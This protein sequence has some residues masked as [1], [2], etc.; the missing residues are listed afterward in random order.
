MPVL[1]GFAVLQHLS[2]RRSAVF[3]PVVV[4]T[5][6]AT[7]DT[8]RRALALGATDFLTKPLDLVEVGL[9]VSNLLSLRRLHD[10]VLR[11][12]LTL[13]EMVADRTRDLVVAQQEIVDRLGLAA[14][15][16]D[17]TTGRHTKRVG[18]LAGVLA[19]ALGRSPAEVELLRL[20]SPLHD[21]GKIA[22]PDAI[23]LKPGKL[24]PEEYEVVKSHTTIGAR[25]LS[26]S[27]SP[28]LR[29]A[30][31]I[32]LAHH[33]RWD[34]SGYLGLAGEEIPVDARLV[35][36][37]DVFDALVSERPYKRPWPE[38]AALAEISSLAGAHFDPVMT[39]TF[40]A[41]AAEGAFRE[42]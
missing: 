22:I 2:R 25:I 10:D 26:E 24:T 23:L 19:A 33:E 4:L 17:D 32:A 3:L 16:R 18:R 38:E 6:D 29:T 39:E 12:Q 11:Y 37:V 5:A 9:R 13:E 42:D 1:D 27:T 34:G 31:S 21:I 40:L 35:S 36:L 20:A 30:E 8:R 15:Y 14:E 41:L 28:V 7:S